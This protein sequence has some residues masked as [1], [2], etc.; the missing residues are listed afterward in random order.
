MANLTH[1]RR[2]FIHSLM[3]EMATCIVASNCNIWWHNQSMHSIFNKPLFIYQSGPQDFCLPTTS[4]DL[5]VCNSHHS[6]AV[7]A[8]QVFY[9]TVCTFKAIKS[10][11]IFLKLIDITG[12]HALLNLP[13]TKCFPCSASLHRKKPFSTGAC[14]W[15][16]TSAPSSTCDETASSTAELHSIPRTYWLPAHRDFQTLPQS[17]V[18]AQTEEL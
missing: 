4:S 18:N 16:T 6:V 13:L 3:K 2:A 7:T 8:G 11:L 10:Q 1:Q 9:F 5:N 15:S 17:G 14:R 12:P